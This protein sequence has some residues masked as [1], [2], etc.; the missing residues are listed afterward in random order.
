MNICTRPLL[1]MR[2]FSAG[3]F[4][5]LLGLRGLVPPTADI[6]PP[7]Q[8]VQRNAAHDGSTGQ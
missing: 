6:A 7:L 1:S 2:T 4:T 3:A 8:K 5:G